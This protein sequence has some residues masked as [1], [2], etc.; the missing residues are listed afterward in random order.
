LYVLANLRNTH[1]K[2]PKC[3]V[4]GEK[5]LSKG[6]LTEQ[7]HHGGFLR[8]DFSA[9][10]PNESTVPGV[11]KDQTRL[12]QEKR[13][14]LSLLL[15]F[16]ESLKRQPKERD[17]RRRGGVPKH[18]REKEYDHAFLPLPKN[19]ESMPGEVNID[20]QARESVHPTKKSHWEGK[21]DGE[22]RK[23]RKKDKNATSVRCS[24]GEKKAILQ[25]GGVVKKTLGKNHGGLLDKKYMASG[26]IVGGG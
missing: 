10:K 23:G 11:R 22:L 9:H 13:K 19:G 5:I 8:C 25:K 15:V 4:V 20:G 17:P 1:R 6:R 21:T 3:G 16:R 24:T 26:E 2:P 14:R 7:S 18:G 12:L